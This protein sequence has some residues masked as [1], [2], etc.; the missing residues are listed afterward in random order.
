MVI[1]NWKYYILNIFLYNL[2]KLLEKNKNKKGSFIN[3]FIYK[4]LL[5]Y[6]MLNIIL[7]LEHKT[8]NYCFIKY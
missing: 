1:L 3:L 6:N 8:I 7:F 4:Y 2:D 5:N